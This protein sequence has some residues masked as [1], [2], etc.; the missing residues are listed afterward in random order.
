[1]GIANK[2]DSLIEDKW[3]IFAVKG[4]PGS[5]VK[6]LFKHIEDM[7][8]LNG[9]YTEIYHC[10][11]DPTNIDFI[12]LPE[13][14]AA[15]LD[16]SGHIVDYEKFLP[17]RKYKRMLDFDQFLDISAINPYQ[18]KLAAT[19]DR[20][21]R[22]LQEAISFIQIAKKLHDELETNYVPAMDFARIEA[23]RKELVDKLL[24]E[25]NRS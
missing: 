12:I 4:N 8:I 15:I 5:G 1:M 10:P 7:S 14:K 13:N 11:F 24:E 23:F 18:E 9:N 3:T 2:V 20:F 25:L 19:K 21:Q 17:T 16:I 6:G 22:G